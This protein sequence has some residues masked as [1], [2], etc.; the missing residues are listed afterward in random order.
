MDKKKIK[1][2]LKVI[3]RALQLID[4]QLDE[5]DLDIDLEAFLEPPKKKKRKKMRPAP[6]QEPLR[7]LV[8]SESPVQAAT[9]SPH[10]SR[11]QHIEKL[12]SIDCWPEA[13][14]GHLAAKPTAEDQIN[15]ANAVL[16]MMIDRSTE[17]THFLD[18]GCGDGWV[19]KEMTRRG[20]ASSTGFDLLPSDNWNQH[21]GVTFT[22]VFKDLNPD[23][24]DIIMLYDVLDH[25]ED[26]VGLMKQVH[27]LM[28][29]NGI[30]YARCHPWSS[31]HASHLYK[32]GLNRAYIHLFLTWEELIE[33]GHT[34][35]FTRQEKNALEAYRWWASSNNFRIVKEQLHTEPVHEFFLVPAFKDLLINEQ[36]LEGERRES[37]F[38]D[39][40]LEFVDLKL[41]RK[42]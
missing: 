3:G 6:V 35:M 36:Q 32:S 15:R 37:F 11:Q 19:A 14:P 2:Y 23:S 10:N 20:V 29:R 21:K 17:G 5:D 16:D 18:F 24:Y 8:V 30:V 13:V 31:K 12:L 41:V 42:E 27:S 9:D 40:Q 25:C 22:N 26:P 7:H 4:E 28:K 39:M 1:Q 34:P 33:L 38:N